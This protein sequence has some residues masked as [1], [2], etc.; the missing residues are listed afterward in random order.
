MYKFTILGILGY[1]KIRDSGDYTLLIC[2]SFMKTMLGWEIKSFEKV[3]N[4]I[5]LMRLSLVRMIIN[6][7]LIDK[8][9][10]KSF[11]PRVLRVTRCTILSW[12][13]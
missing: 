6:F 9:S 3:Q 2:Q 5:A 1:G 12:I 11:K 8:H 4:R 13:A 10:D 7:Y